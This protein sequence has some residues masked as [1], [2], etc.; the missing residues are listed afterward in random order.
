MH[1][2]N[3]ALNQQS[4]PEEKLKKA[5]E[6]WWPDLAADLQQALVVFVRRLLDPELPFTV[7]AEFFPSQELV[8]R[9][10]D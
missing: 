7:V 9:D 5:F 10:D 4:L 8:A 6:R 3:A 1:A 2:I